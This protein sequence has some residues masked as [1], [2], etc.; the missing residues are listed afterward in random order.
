MGKYSF[1]EKVKI[2]KE[3]TSDQHLAADATLLA[4]KDP[5]NDLV[6][7]YKLGTRVSDEEV[8]YRL[9]D[10][11][12]VEEIRKTRRFFEKQADK[13]VA[14][15]AAE[16]AAEEEAARAAAEQAAAEEAARAAAE[17]AADQ[18]EPKPETPAIEE[19]AHVAQEAQE[20][21]IE[22]ND[23]A[24]EALDTANEALDAAQ[25]ALDIQKKTD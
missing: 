12:P 4:Q 1:K 23:T 14:R 24:N 11:A 2:H 9:L 16:Q 10:F 6:R 21:A 18:P 22:A 19:V 3:L 20:T 5:T 8:L 25:E 7:R 17:K 13:E 15:A